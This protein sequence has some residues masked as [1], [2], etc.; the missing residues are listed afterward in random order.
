[1]QFGNSEKMRLVRVLRTSVMVRVGG[2]WEYLEHF[3]IKNDPCRGIF[4]A[5]AFDRSL[6]QNFIVTPISFLA[7]FSL[8]LSFFSTGTFRK[9]TTLP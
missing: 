5:V 4:F 7:I 2:G 1:M 9:A 6:F 8:S 3:L